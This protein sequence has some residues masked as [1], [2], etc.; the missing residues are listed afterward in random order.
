MPIDTN[1]IIKPTLYG[2][3]VR[4]TRPKNTT[5]YTAND[6]LGP[7][8]VTQTGALEFKNMGPEGGGEILIMST[9]FL[10]NST[11]LIASEAAHTMYLYSVNPPSLLADNVAWDMDSVD[12]PYFLGSLAIGTPVDIGSSL[13][14]AVDN[15][16]KQVK[17]KSSSM[18]GYMTTA[19]AYTPTSSRE[20]YV[21]VHARAL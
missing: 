14:I 17:L 12:Q 13:F 16:N 3:T 8:P 15:I 7:D 4:F 18:W 11:A 19:G 10:V 21:G 1:A 9:Y 2:A 5:A 20:Y 6:V